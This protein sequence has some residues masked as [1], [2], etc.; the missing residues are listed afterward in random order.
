MPLLPGVFELPNHTVEIFYFAVPGLLL[1]INK[2]RKLNGRVFS[3]SRL[4]L[5]LLLFGER[6]KIIT[7]LNK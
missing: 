5:N 1:P 2:T 6:K 7:D 3:Y 4:S